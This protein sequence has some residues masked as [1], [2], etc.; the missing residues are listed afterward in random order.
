LKKI[1][2]FIACF[3]GLA[4]A[5]AQITSG[6]TSVIIVTAYLP[7]VQETKKIDILPI[8]EDPK[9]KPPVYQY[10]F[11]NVAY[12]P[13]AVYSPIDPIFIKPEEKEELSDNY[14]EVG[15][16]NYLTSYL[17]ASIHNTQDK[18]YMYGLNVKHHAANASKDPNQALF[19]QNQITAFGSREKGNDL[20]GEMDYQR[21]VVHYYGYLADT[22]ERSLDDI[23]QIYND[24]N[25]KAQW[26]RQQSKV[27]NRLNLKSDVNLGFNLFDKLSESE[28]T[29]RVINKN[30]F[31]AGKGRLHLDLGATYTQLTETAKYN[32]LFIDFKPHYEL[33]YKKWNLDI[34]ANLNYLSD[35]NGGVIKPAPYLKAETYLV[36]KILRGYFGIT[37]DFQKNT[38]KSL[39]YE[40]LFLGNTIQYANTYVL[41]FQGGMNGSFKRFVAFG[42]N[43]SQEFIKD[44]YFFVSDTNALRNFTTVKDDMSRLTFSG[45][46]KFNVNQ[47]IEIGFRGN[48]YSYSLTAEKEAWHLPSYDAALFSTVRLADRIYIRGGYFA[49]S[50][51]NARD[52]N[53]KE[54]VLAAINDVNLG[55]EYRYKKNISGFIRVNNIL[56]Q[57][58]ELWNNYRA[59]GLNA[60]AGITFS[61]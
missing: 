51:R 50:A 14:L 12:K 40:N 10:V 60:L 37:G 24:V 26:S 53:S 33:T 35:T 48:V 54:F 44:Q 39:S 46:L 18:Y 41:K 8:M 34:G 5:K 2:L 23:H 16:G 31:S 22:S 42:I 43:I 1:I 61:L 59:Q 45:E 56:N 11:P 30:D 15:G 57:R 7:D 21:N 47:H 13:K 25:A 6:D 29:F 20:F 27:N 52:L 58:Y 17:N 55:F 28:N 36:P 4:T 49:T 38:L 9:V 3:T 19:S 32:R